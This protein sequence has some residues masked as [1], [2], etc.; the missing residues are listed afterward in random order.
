[1]WSHRR[2]D[3]PQAASPE[4]RNLQANR[5]LKPPPANLEG[6]TQK[7]KEA[8][9]PTGTTVDSVPSRLG[10]S[11]HVKGEISGAEDL[12]IDGLVEGLVQL[13][14]G[15]L[16]IGTTAKVTADV[17][18]SEVV[19]CGN[20]KG[21]VRAKSR[22]EISRD[23]SVTGDLTTGQIMIEDGAYFK[24]SVEIDRGADKAADRH[25]SS[26]TALH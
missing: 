19:V 7:N 25:V 6:T 22:I 4:S 23:G 5:P 2:L 17:V 13:D 16:T 21:T 11:L 24:G 14:G 15:K 3:A 9:R 1:M 12:L 18:A 10:P 26:Q 20:L 8:V